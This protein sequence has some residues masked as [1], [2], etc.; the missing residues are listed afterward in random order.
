M[1]NY[2]IAPSKDGTSV[3][4]NIPDSGSDQ[5]LAD[6]TFAARLLYTLTLDFKYSL[7]ESTPCSIL[8]WAL[9]CTLAEDL[10]AR[11]GIEPVPFNEIHRGKDGMLTHT[12]MVA[13]K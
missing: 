2:T 4:W 8:D 7:R 6:I 3:R 11:H 13:P 12:S 9:I 10:L 1:N 5:R